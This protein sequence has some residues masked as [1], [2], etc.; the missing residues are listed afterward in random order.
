MTDHNNT[1]GE[2]TMTT[3]TPTPDA[4]PFTV[5]RVP[6]PP[7]DTDTEYAG[8]RVTRVTVHVPS[9]DQTPL[10]VGFGIA[11]FSV[12]ILAVLALWISVDTPPRVTYVESAA[13]ENTSMNAP[14][15][16]R[17]LAEA[18]VIRGL[19]EGKG[20]QVRVAAGDPLPA[21]VMVRAEDAC[22]LA[23]GK[24]LLQSD[25]PSCDVDV[26][27]GFGAGR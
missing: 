4:G 24:V 27:T 25:P 13:V 3:E 11:L 19:R 6:A 1:E 21:R 23:G 20:A 14:M 18:N 22:V 17:A 8:A 26:P 15:L 12:L 10:Y 9:T 2:S 5:T 7:S 16:D